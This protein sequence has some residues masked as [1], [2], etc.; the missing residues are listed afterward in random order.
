MNE[1]AR[2]RESEKIE[3]EFVSGNGIPGGGERE[4]RETIRLN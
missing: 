2:E 3:Q 1:G 4:R